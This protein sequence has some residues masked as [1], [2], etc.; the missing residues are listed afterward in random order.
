MIHKVVSAILG[1]LSLCAGMVALVGYAFPALQ[2]LIPPAGRI[3]YRN[4]TLSQRVLAVLIIW[5]LTI[6]AFYMGFRFLRFLDS[7]RKQ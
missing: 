5:S 6:A 2:D 3:V 7:P 1:A 4:D